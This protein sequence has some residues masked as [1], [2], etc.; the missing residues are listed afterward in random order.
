MCYSYTHSFIAFKLYRIPIK[1]FFSSRLLNTQTE[2]DREKSENYSYV[3]LLLLL[4]FRAISIVVIQVLELSKKRKEVIHLNMNGGAA[5]A[6]YMY[7]TVY[8]AVCVAA[9]AL[10]GDEIKKPL[11]MFNKWS[12]VCEL[13]LSKTTVSMHLHE[14]TIIVVIV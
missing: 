5:A 10:L 1:V 13:R 7:C 11:H 6:V 3:L 12:F 4:L 2:R 14:L 9:T 8:Y